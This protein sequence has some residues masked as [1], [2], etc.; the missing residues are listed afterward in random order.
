[1]IPI[2]LKRDIALSLVAGFTFCFF[3]CYALALNP[4]TLYSGYD[5]TIYE[6]MGLGMLQGRIPYVDLF[7][8]KGF[9]LYIINAAGQWLSP[10]H[11]GLYLIL[12]CYLSLTFLCW[13]RTSD[14]LVGPSLRYFPASVALL[15][16]CLCEGGNMT[17]T[18]SLGAISLPIYFLVRYVCEGRMIGFR[19][20][21]YI[22]ICLGIVANIRLNNVVPALA[23]CLYMFIDLC[24]K[25]DFLKLAYSAYIVLCGFCLVSL[26]LAAL[27]VW[28]YGIQ[29]L[30]DYWFGQVSFNLLYASHYTQNPL[31]MAG[32][33]YF[34]L[35]MLIV[36]LC[37]R[38]N[39]RNCLM[40]FTLATFL[41]T[42]LTTGKAYFAHYFTLFAPLVVLSLSL[43]LG[44]SLN[45]G[46]RTWYFIGAGHVALLVVLVAMFHEELSQVVDSFV[47]REKA[48]DK[49]RN[50]LC[51]LSDRQKESV[52]NYNTK[53]A[54]ACV[55][56]CSGLTQ[57]NRV[58]LPWQAE[59]NYGIEE[60]GRIEEMCPEVI[61]ICENTL[62]E[63]G[64]SDECG[65]T[66]Q[67]SIF[68]TQNYHQLHRMEEMIHDKRVCI[69]IRN[70]TSDN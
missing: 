2:A 51:C 5:Q 63:A 21:L 18:W 54:G 23:V 61:L 15:F 28:L 59:G 36:M 12:S 56:E 1:M 64:R 4:F 46:S 25:K 66:K 33:L 49:C 9:L 26:P 50:V 65:G 57:C 58:F 13:L 41:L 67:D 7:D 30:A 24:H 6:Q 3:F 68:I 10:G 34:P 70:E 31:W 62:W 42:L 40:W 37:V 48:I 53:F 27:Y 39:Y 69:Y 22:G 32:G 60:I 19:E 55:L 35:F 44:K 29:H 45:I 52:W 11:T 8:H 16:A 47:L 20:C 14:Y 38:R 43:A 17:E